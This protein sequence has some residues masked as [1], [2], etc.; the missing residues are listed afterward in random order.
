VTQKYTNIRF[1]WVYTLCYK[2]RCRDFLR[3]ILC[4]FLPF[5]LLHHSCPLLC[6]NPVLLQPQKSSKR[7]TDNS[8]SSRNNSC[9]LMISFLLL[10][11]FKEI[12]LA[13]KTLKCT[14]YLSLPF[15]QTYRSGHPHTQHN[16]SLRDCRPAPAA[17]LWWWQKN[18]HQALLNRVPH[19]VPSPRA[20]CH[21]CCATTF[22]CSQYAG[23]SWKC[24]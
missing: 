22:K 13:G 10:L 5:V 3:S 19:F 15:A 20:H 6:G 1:I 14:L 16:S 18:Q 2:G 17:K 23:S 9:H 24:S 11:N 12:L 8:P 7:W 21:P 4:F